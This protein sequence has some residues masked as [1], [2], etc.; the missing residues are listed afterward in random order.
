[1]RWR[2][3]KQPDDVLAEVLARHF[4][5]KPSDREALLRPVMGAVVVVMLRSGEP[6]VAR[7][8]PVRP[9]CWPGSVAARGNEVARVP[10][11]GSRGQRREQREV[12][13]S[14]VGLRR[15]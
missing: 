5:R 14:D 9:R 3:G 13:E 8:R 11:S 12:P 4:R 15:G 1:M 7:P 2:R 10:G 6:L